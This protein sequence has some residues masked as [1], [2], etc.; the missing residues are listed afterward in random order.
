MPLSEGPAAKTLHETKMERKNVDITKH[1]NAEDSTKIK[2]N[3]HPITTKIDGRQRN[4][5]VTKTE[6]N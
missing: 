3:Q 5:L 2:K 1:N 4:V 6:V